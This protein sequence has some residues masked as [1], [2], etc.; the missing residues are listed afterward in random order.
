M[1]RQQRVVV[2]AE[3]RPEHPE[4]TTDDSVLEGRL[5]AFRD[6]RPAVVGIPRAAQAPVHGGEYLDRVQARA[7]VQLRRK[8][9]LEVTHALRLVVLG[10]LRGDALQRLG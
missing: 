5:A 10:Q 1:R 7:H 8:A 4:R 3:A 2:A 6:L 9:H